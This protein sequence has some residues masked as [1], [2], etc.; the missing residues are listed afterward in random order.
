MEAPVVEK[1]GSSPQ[2]WSVI[3]QRYFNNASGGDITVREIGLQQYAAGLE[4]MVIRDILLA[5]YTV[6]HAGQ[7]LA[8]FIFTLSIPSAI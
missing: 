6:A 2:I 5:D 1:T 8:R 7:F 4:T 3:H